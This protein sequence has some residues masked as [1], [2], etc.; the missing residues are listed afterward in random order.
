MK[1]EEALQKIK[2]NF[3]EKYL[4]R[5]ELI[6]SEK[7]GN[8]ESLKLKFYQSIIDG[9][10]NIN[11]LWTSDEVI[12]DLKTKIDSAKEEDKERILL[13][14]IETYDVAVPEIRQMLKKY[15]RILKNMQIKNLK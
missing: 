6:A 15:D 3:G 13:E 9:Y 7:F 5:V 12:K 10:T 1:K 14:I 2:D 8:K 11:K 4:V